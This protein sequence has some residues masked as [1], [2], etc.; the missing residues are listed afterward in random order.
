MQN[1]GAIRLFAILLAL[2]SLYQ[3]IFT[4]HARKVER[5]ATEFAIK[6]AGPDADQE[7]LR[8]YEVQFLD[9]MAHEVVYN[10]LFGLR[11]YTYLETKAR[12]I[13]F[14]LDLRGGMNLILEVQVADI[15]DALSNYNQDD[16]FRSALQLA[17]ERE[18][19]STRDFITLFGEAFEEV[20]PD[21]SLAAIFNTVELRDRVR[22]DSSNDEV[23]RVLRRES[24]AAISNA[25]NIL[26]TRIDRFGVVQP[27]VQRLPQSPGRVLIELP[28]VTEPERVRNL[29]RGTANLEFWETFDNQTIQPYLIQANEIITRRVMAQRMDSAVETETTDD[30]D[31]IADQLEGEDDETSLLRDLDLEDI[32]T[33]DQDL[34]T[35]FTILQPVGRASG[36]VVGVAAS[37]H[38]A[39]IDEWLQLEEVRSAL[40]RDLKL[41][42][43]VK[44]IPRNDL[45]FWVPN[46]GDT[47]EQ[48]FQLVAIRAN[49]MDGRAPLEGDVITNA[50]DRVT[51]TGAFEVAMSMNSEGARTWARLTNANIGKSIAIV[52]DG[53][54]YSFPTV[55]N[56]IRGGQSSITGNFSPEEAK[57]LANIL[58]SGS[59]PAPAHIVEDHV[60]G[61]SLGAEAVSAGLK[62][63]IWAFIV[64][65]IYMMI[66]YGFKAGVV[67]DI[68]LVSNMFFVMGVLAAFNAV[69]TLPGIAG[70]VL[71]IGMSVDANVLIYE[72]IREELKAGK[73]LRLA[74]SDGYKNAFSA[75]ID[76]N[77][78]TFLTG[79]ILFMFGTGPVKG[80]A[81]TL[82]IGIATSFFSAVFITRL[83]YEWLLDSKVDIKFGS[84]FT[85]NLFKN[86]KIAF[87][88]KRKVA[89]ILSGAFF[90]IAV[91]SLSVRGLQQGIDFTGGRTYLVRFAEN[92][93]SVE[94]FSSVSEAFEGANT[95]VKTFGTAN[96]VRIATNYLVFETDEVAD[97]RVEDRLFAGVQPFLPSG[98]TQDTFMSDYVMSSQKVGPTIA[99]DI[100]SRAAYAVVF[101]LIVI[102]LYILLRFRT[103]QLGVGALA[104]VIHDVMF[105]LGI[106]SLFYTIAPFALEI[107]QAFIAAILTVIGYSIN[108]TVVVFDRIREYRLLYPKRNLREVFNLA[109]NSTISRT[110]NTSMTTLVVL[111]VIFV[112]GS[113]VIRGFVFAL[114]VGVLVGTYS[115]IFVAS[116]IAYN[117][118]KQKEK[119]EAKKA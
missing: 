55:Q 5:D 10:F 54:V 115:S 75:I 39:Q 60:V 87:L 52:L 37:R 11:Q 93:N 119:A 41:L 25:F 7:T 22:Y 57:D 27:N 49:T 73:G 17:R 69:L 29:L 31:V 97:S 30:V 104:A 42:W 20:A 96:Q 90:L 71:T 70:I 112:F 15:V 36:P 45:Q 100:K 28:G 44:P 72:R 43:T 91:G 58:R 102:F 110:I 12:E 18:M 116:P 14:G 1:K 84:K 103:W 86:T 107:D 105:V 47:R 94:V 111:L 65:L 19:T 79:L 95:E 51:Q 98:T 85:S 34:R 67:A 48:F 113:E 2:V 61:P 46:A 53:Y 4:Y 23:I 9:S 99:A 78:T 68:A 92:V 21:A 108:D 50:S 66:Y 109:I 83:V 56:E 64:V 33:T 77:V 6:M 35:L 118:I 101:S 80:F 106:F 114:I 16:N 117:F 59:L 40:P 82:M 13:N 74:I 26:R 24:E 76:A 3:L 62:S 32:D 81:T 88:E 8:G 38:M 63:F 89:F